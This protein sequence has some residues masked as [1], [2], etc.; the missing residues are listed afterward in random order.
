MLQPRTVHFMFTG[1][2]ANT[3]DIV[4]YR[5]TMH[6]AGYRLLLLHLSN[7]CLRHVIGQQ[8]YQP[9]FK[10]KGMQGKGFATIYAAVLLVYYAAC[11]L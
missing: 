2:V 6:T 8:Y 1:V 7:N 4:T 3:T 9:R 11:L 5:Q 10:N